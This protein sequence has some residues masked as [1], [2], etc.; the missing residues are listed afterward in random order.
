M[1][2]DIEEIIQEGCKILAGQEKPRYA[3]VH[4]QLE[5]CYNMDIPYHT[6]RNRSLGN[7]VSF[8]K[9]SV[10]KQLLSPEAERVLVDWVIFLSDTAHPLNKQSIQK[11]AE[12]LCGK[13]PSVNWI[14]WFLK[15]WPEIQLGRP[16]GLDPKRGQAFNRPVVGRHFDLLLEIVRKSNIPEENIYNM[17]EKGCQRGGGR[18][19]SGRKYFVPRSRRPKYKQRSANLELITIIECVCADGTSFLPGFVFAG[20][21]FAPEWFTVH[22]QISYVAF[23]CRFPSPQSQPSC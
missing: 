16:S 20:K 2:H 22:P 4:Q 23:S 11:R 8:S 14:Y 10:R 6:L 13:K 19:Q 1:L 21:E 3:D 17:D 5:S 9:A 18:K 15:H 7:S 12:A